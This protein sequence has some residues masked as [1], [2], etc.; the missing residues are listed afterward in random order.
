MKRVLSS[1]LTVVISFCLVAAFS[2]VSAAKAETIK[3]G[4][5]L[6][7]TGGASFLG[8]P[9]SRTL[10]MMAQE[11]NAAGGINGNKIELIIKENSSLRKTRSLPSSARP[12][13]AKP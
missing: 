11:I 5:I 6:A 2:P 3:V 12:P 9:E 1:I 13:A 10:E 8:T 4:A 7:V